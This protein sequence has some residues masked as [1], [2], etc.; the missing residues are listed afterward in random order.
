MERQRF[1]K[2]LRQPETLGL[3]ACDE[4]RAV[5]QEYPYLGIVKAMIAIATFNE[6]G[7]ESFAEIKEAAISIPDRE[8]F[9]K[10]LFQAKDRYLILQ[11]TKHTENTITEDQDI[12]EHT[13]LKGRN[14]VISE[15]MFI[16]P[17]IDLSS[18]H[19]ELSAE[20]AYLEE[21][22]KS[23]DELKEMIAARLRELEAEK[24]GVVD[25]EKK[26]KKLTK[27]E[28]IEKFIAENPSISRPKAEFFNP[29]S[30]AQNSITDQEEIVSETLAG[31]YIKQGH[32]EKAISVY[33]KL[34]LKYPEKS[35][36]FAGLIEAL[37]KE[38]KQ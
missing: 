6:D 12:V 28:I 10:T 23:L 38:V 31:I 36:Y 4:L 1:L 9:R 18:T 17:E 14:S 21:K 11:E 15:K 32:K 37:K 2:Y 35:V 19:E 20:M 25:D 29:I 24:Q 27:K 13:N 16:I 34:C 8:L 30:V 7:N 22:R 33:R 26:E 3:A 5:L